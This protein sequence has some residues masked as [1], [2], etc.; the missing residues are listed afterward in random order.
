MVEDDEDVQEGQVDREVSYIP[1]SRRGTVS[2]AA[3]VSEHVRRE[4]RLLALQESTT[5]QRLLCIAIND[6]LEAKGRERLADETVRPRGG[7]AHKRG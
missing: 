6:L 4:L 7:A 3:H 5:L 2:V 1:P